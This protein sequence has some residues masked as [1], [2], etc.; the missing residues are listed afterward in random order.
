M[1][2][3]KITLAAAAAVSTVAVG[4]GVTYAMVSAPEPLPAPKV[5]APAPPA[6]PQAPALPD[7]APSGVG[8]P[9]APKVNA[10]AVPRGVPHAVQTSVRASDVGKNAAEA[11]QNAADTAAKGVEAAKGA[12]AG[13]APRCLPSAPVDV[14]QPD[15]PAAP[16]VPNVPDV[17]ALSCSSV[18]AAVV[19]HTPA[20]ETITAI[21]GMQLVSTQ[22]RT[23][24]AKGGDVCAKVQS[25]K[26]LAGQSLT[27]ERLQGVGSLEQA[28]QVMGL[29]QAVQPLTL[30]GGTFWQTPVGGGE[31][32]GLMW[33]PDPGVAVFVGGSPAYQI[34]M[35]QIAMQLAQVG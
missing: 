31:G 34:Q 35:R 24:Q 29:P 9:S 6:V 7:C 16:N 25:F 21:P 15:V 20:M 32:A 10:P 28:R 13:A 11:K 17:P 2:P 8:A 12:A 30:G 18:P 19:P 33:S 14:P 26:G 27:V 3:L 1:I 22:T 23:L 4:S 5:A